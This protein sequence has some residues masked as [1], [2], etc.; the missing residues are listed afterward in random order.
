M[1]FKYMDPNDIISI[2]VVLITLGVGAY[3]F[4]ITNANI[5]NNAPIWHSG[6]GYYGNV[7]NASQMALNNTSRLGGTVF[8]ILGV[9]ITI[10][11]IMSIIGVIYG[12]LRPKY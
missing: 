5:Q 1:K 9:C 10:G 3:A 7:G 8:N 6:S 11:A 2:I 12:Y 4:F